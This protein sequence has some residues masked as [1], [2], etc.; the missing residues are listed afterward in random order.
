MA[1]REDG[2]IRRL[3]EK[4]SLVAFRQV[5]IIRES[6][7]FERTTE[8]AETADMMSSCLLLTL[9]LALGQGDRAEWNL[10]PQLVPG[11]ELVYS[12]TS[13]EES[14]TP[15]IQ[16]QRV[17]RIENHLFILS[18]SAKNL[19][20]AFMT[21][22]SVREPGEEV[23][24]KSASIRLELAK[25]DDR[26][27][28]KPANAT[29]QLHAPAGLPPV[30]ETGCIVEVP[31]LVGKNSAWEVVETGRPLVTW[32]VH[33]PESAGGMACVKL[34]GQQQSDDWDRP[35]ADRT[36][37]RRKD[38]V[39]MSTQIGV[40]VKVE[41][42]IE[43]REPGRR[44]PSQRVVTSYS[45]ESRLKYPGKLLDD[46]KNE[47][48][49]SRRFLEEA[50]PLLRQPGSQLESL[51][52]KVAYHVDHHPTTPYRKVVTQLAQRIDGARR[53]ELLLAEYAEEPPEPIRSLGVGQKS[54][55]FT[56]QDLA[57]RTSTRLS[58][59]LGQPVLVIYYSPHTKTG[60]DVLEFAKQL[61]EKSTGR[62]AILAMAVTKEPDFAVRQQTEMK[63]PFP[64]Y[65][66]T[67]M[68]IAFNVE[69]TPRFI[70]LDADGV[71][72]AS[73]TGWAPHVPDEIRE[74]IRTAA[75]RNK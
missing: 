4:T 35:R 64:V 54:P 33:G 39:W 62:C 70:V 34:V 71:I 18:G 11:V 47:I 69:A 7:R 25:L 27:R 46:R 38:V 55:D 75:D 12:G 30:I 3:R 50:S 29:N 20:I 8:R 58:K 6:L 37:W 43:R 74:A 13:S 32:T 10:T 44:D 24:F 1:S 19:D 5:V 31:S 41:R 23:R 28:L 42:T 45:L 15:G 60:V 73:T 49:A 63:L 17:Y 72:R 22:L 66:G 21:S 52:R 9:T 36:A 14:L 51:S 68:R 53:G 2:A 67:A 26:G 56:A 48:L 57:T 59:I 16:H 65:D 40:A 61:A